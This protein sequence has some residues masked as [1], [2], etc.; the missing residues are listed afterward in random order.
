MAA[1]LDRIPSPVDE[2]SPSRGFCMDGKLFSGILWIETFEKIF[3]E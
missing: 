3:Y 1:S 2:P